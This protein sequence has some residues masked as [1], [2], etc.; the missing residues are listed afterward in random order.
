[1]IDWPAIY[2]HQADRECDPCGEIYADIATDF[3]RHYSYGLD[4][5]GLSERI[6]MHR[7]FEELRRACHQYVPDAVLR[8]TA[9]WVYSQLGVQQ[10]GNVISIRPNPE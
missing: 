10:K 4:L 2:S 6:L 1:M 7:P 5:C 8:N 9:A 3:D